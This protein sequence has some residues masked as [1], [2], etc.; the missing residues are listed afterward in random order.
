MFY[1]FQSSS[2]D[3]EGCIAGACAGVGSAGN[4]A[5]TDV[6]VDGSCDFSV[7]AAAADNVAIS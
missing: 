1:G 4:G 6:G 5:T 3:V 7:L 2:C